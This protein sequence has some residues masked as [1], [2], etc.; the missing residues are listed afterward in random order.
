MTRS[1]GEIR[2]EPILAFAERGPSRPGF[3]LKSK[4]LSFERLIADVPVQIAYSLDGRKFAS[5]SCGTRVKLF[6][7]FTARVETTLRCP[8]RALCS[9]WSPTQNELAI[10]NF[11]GTIGIW[12]VTTGSQRQVIE[13]HVGPV[14][15][16]AFSPDGQLLVSKS[17][18]D[19]GRVWRS[20]R[21][22]LVAAFAAAGAAALRD[23]LAYHP[24]EHLLATTGERNN[25]IN[26]GSLRQTFC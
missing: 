2:F 10:G 17:L 24:S 8:Q 26:A 15:S 13:G 19:S 21:W 18:D 14:T 16:I 7:A 20:D 11:D 1:P 3:R 12:D 6:D 4:L 9:S 22:E 5:T 25:L 23:D